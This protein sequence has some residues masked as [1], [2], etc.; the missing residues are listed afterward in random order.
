MAINESSEKK[1]KL[2]QIYDWIKSNFPY[3]KV[4]FGGGTEKHFEILIKEDEQ[5]KGGGGGHS[6]NFFYIFYKN[7]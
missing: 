2:C 3:Y 4:I 5:R 6:F 7:D 1:L